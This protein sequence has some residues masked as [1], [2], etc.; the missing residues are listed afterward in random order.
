MLYGA[1][2]A[3]TRIHAQNLVS[4]MHTFTLGSSS[5]TSAIVERRRSISDCAVLDSFLCLLLSYRKKIM[6]FYS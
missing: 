4:L 2:H 1:C 6:L 5:S 3:V